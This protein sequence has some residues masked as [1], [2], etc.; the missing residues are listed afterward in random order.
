[1]KRIVILA[2]LLLVA[3]APAQAAPVVAVATAIWTGISAIW[4]AAGVGAFLFRTGAALAL[5]FLSSLLRPK[6]KFGDFGPRAGPISLPDLQAGATVPRNIIFGE[7]IVAGTQICPVYV[8]DLE[9]DENPANRRVTE[10]RAL[11]THQIEG[12]TAVIVNGER[13]E[14][15]EML[16]WAAA[17]AVTKTVESLTANSLTIPDD[18][19]DMVPNEFAGQQIGLFYPYGNFLEFK[20]VDSN[21][22][23]AIFVT[24]DWDDHTVSTHNLYAQIFAT[25]TYTTIASGDGQGDGYTLTDFGAGWTP[26]EFVGKKI[27]VTRLN[28]PFSNYGGI[29]TGNTT[30]TVTWTG[31]D[32]IGTDDNGLVENYTISEFTPAELFSYGVTPPSGKYQNRIGFRFHNGDQVVAD[33]FMVGI[34]GTY[35]D[36]PWTEN[37]VGRGIA[38]VVA[39]WYVHPEEPE[40]WATGRP[41]IFFVTRGA[42]F[43]DPREDDSVGGDGSQAWATPGFWQYS[44]NPAVIAYNL[45]RG[46]PIGDPAVGIR[47]GGRDADG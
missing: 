12:V 42:K 17:G 9:D 21:T 37:M 3:A 40:L 33:E 38:Y 20:T 18:A 2:A 10:I 27:F 14:V 30:D 22:E 25:G 24:P 41:E 44:D 15:A 35:P 43:S 47:Y 1:M 36:R 19:D 6:P 4:A 26:D 5:S 31:G 8:H 46:F 23:R 7:T 32:P 39:N 11:A 45:A 34:Y 13:F 28:F 29:V 16:P